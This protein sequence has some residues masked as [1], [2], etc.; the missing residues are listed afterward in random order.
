MVCSA[1]SVVIIDTLLVARGALLPQ[2]LAYTSVATMRR[3]KAGAIKE[4]SGHAF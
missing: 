2:R 1:R 3:D 4:S